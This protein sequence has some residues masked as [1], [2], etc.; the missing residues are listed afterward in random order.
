MRFANSAAATAATVP[1]LSNSGLGVRLISAFALIPIALAAVFFGFPFFDA[2]VLLVGLLMAWE[3][4]RLCSGGTLPVAGI[5]AI[6]ATGIA[7]L[8]VS[9]LGPHRALLVVLA[10][11]LVTGGVALATRASPVWLSAGTLYAGLPC[12]GI[13]WLRADPAHGLASILWMLVLVWAI[14]TGAYAAGRMIGGP[15]LAPSISPKKTWSGLAGGVG[16]GFIVGGVAGLVI[17]GAAPLVLAAVS[18]ALALVAQAGDLAESALKRHFG[19]KD[20]SG[21]IPGHGG[22]LDRIDGLVAVIAVA[23]LASALTGE[24][25]VAWP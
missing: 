15:K 11:A 25:I 17:D 12:V 14:D 21:L 20:S 8:A 16:S 6:V 18:A 10:G 23:A 24:N 3:W 5:V 7:V 9:A 19:V 22:M 1:A 4:S 13:L 2:L